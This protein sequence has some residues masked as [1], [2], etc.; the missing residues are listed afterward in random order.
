MRLN[1]HQVDVQRSVFRGYK[2]PLVMGMMDRAVESL[3]LVAGPGFEPT[4][5]SVSNRLK[6]LTT[7]NYETWKKANSA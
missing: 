7:R 5:V 2:A 1:S 3:G 6:L 4:I